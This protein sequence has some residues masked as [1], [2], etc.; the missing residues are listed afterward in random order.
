MSKGGVCPGRA[1]EATRLHVKS[2][3]SVFMIVRVYFYLASYNAGRGKV[4]KKSRNV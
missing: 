1:M 3:M 4:Y 2:E